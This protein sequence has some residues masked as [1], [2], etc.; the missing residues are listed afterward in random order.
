MLPWAAASDSIP[1][2]ATKGTTLEWKNGLVDV[3]FADL[4]RLASR[5]GEA[6]ALLSPEEASRARRFRFPRDRIRYVIRRGILRSLIGRYTARDPG[7]LDIRSDDKGKPYLAIGGNEFSFRF[8]M[9]DSDGLAAFALGPQASLGVDIERIRDL[10][11]MD[12]IVSRHFTARE[13]EAYFSCPESGRL[14]LFY[15]FWTRK[16][17]VLKALGEGLRRELNTVDVSGYG[18][19]SG[20]LQACIAGCLSVDRIFLVDIKSLP[21]VAAAVASAGSAAHVRV[22]QYGEPL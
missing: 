16:E 5:V 13:K 22:H 18:D 15:R 7:G 21:G 12:E 9:S 3:W 10:P 1:E 6:E 14:G 4:D 11:E 2:S 17:A 20:P 19:P 8:S